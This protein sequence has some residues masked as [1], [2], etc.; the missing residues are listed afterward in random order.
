MC[1]IFIENSARSHILQ[2][3]QVGNLP[4][5]L[6]YY[7]QRFKNLASQKVH[8]LKSLEYFADADKDE[9]PKMLTD[10]Y[11]WEEVKRVLRKEIKKLI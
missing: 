8:I 9:D 6:T 4:D 7:D 5:F 11:S 10:D 1:Y 3:G 2:N